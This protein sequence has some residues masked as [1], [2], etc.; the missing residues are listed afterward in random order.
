MSS[1]K[2]DEVVL[3]IYSQISNVSLTDD[4][5]HR[6]YDPFETPDQDDF[7]TNMFSFNKIKS[8]NANNGKIICNECNI[9][10]FKSL[11]EGAYECDL[12]GQIKEKVSDEELGI[13]ESGNGSLD[14]NTSYNTSESSSAPIRIVG[15]D[16]YKYQRNFVGST[17]DYSKSQKKLTFSQM[18]NAVYQYEGD[19]IPKNIV[20]EAAN[21]YV[22]VQKHCI[23]R[24]DPRKGTMAACLYRMCRAY[25]ITKKPKEIAKIFGIEQS[26]LSN[27]EKTLA[28]LISSEA[29]AIKMTIKEQ[30]TLSQE[31]QLAMGFMK[32][33][34]IKLDIPDD[35]IT[36]TP[37]D[38]PNYKLFALKVIRFTT[39]YVIA[40]NNITSTKCA[41]I[42]YI[43]AISNLELNI[44]REKIE[45]CC[46]ISRATYNRF[47]KSV[48]EVINSE[49]PLLQKVKSRLRHLFKK[50]NMSLDSKIKLKK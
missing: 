6:I 37:Q 26:E 17:S 29:I 12:C 10:M 31:E 13:Q 28:E 35:E 5:D 23:K 22:D 36:D 48:Y 16:T 11:H 38:R 47:I 25:G 3:D 14:V 49:E 30:V 9:E 45:D 50:F 18:N 7:D 21:L 1:K 39:E 27:G 24:G 42:L 33:Y 19:K 46:K 2:F 4:L 15:P 20:S 40:I 32:E 43:I 34:F 44:T 8:N 41:G